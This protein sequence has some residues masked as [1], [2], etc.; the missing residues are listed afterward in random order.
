M[1]IRDRLKPEQ[2]LLPC[3]KRL[4]NLLLQDVCFQRLTL[5]LPIVQPPVSYTHL[6]VY[7]RQ[8]YGPS[9]S[10]KA[11]AA[12]AQVGMFRRKSIGK[13]AHIGICLLY[14]SILFILYSCHPV[15]CSP[16][17]DHRSH[18]AHKGLWIISYSDELDMGT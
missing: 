7:K 4:C 6:D 5:L 14:T 12:L 16:Q 10:S 2:N 1:C 8:P 9:N 15:L 18:P 17:I 13:I 3:K 11:G